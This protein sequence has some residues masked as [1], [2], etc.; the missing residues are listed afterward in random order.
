MATLPLILSRAKLTN[1]ERIF[2][3]AS[4]WISPATTFSLVDRKT[5]TIPSVFTRASTATYFDRNGIL[6][7]AA[8]NEP[9]IEWDPATGACL[10]WRIWDAVTN[11][12]R[13]STMVGA[14]AG[15]PGTLPT[16]WSQFFPISGVTRTVVGTG[17]ENGIDYLDLRLAGTPSAAGSYFLQFDT[18]TSAVASNGQTWTTSVFLKVASG[19]LTGIN[20]VLVSTSNRNSL[21]N[22][23]AAGSTSVT[24]T[25][26]LRRFSSTYTNADA[27]T[28]YEIGLIELQLSGAA[29]EITLRVGLPQLERAGAA[30]PVVKTS[31]VAASSTADVAS[32]TGAAFAGIWNADESTIVCKFFSDNTAGSGR[33]S[34]LFDIGA[35]GAF[36]TTGYGVF[37]NSAWFI[38]PAV[39]PMN[40]SSAVA[41]S[42]GTKAI[43]TMAA[44]FKA[45]DS[46]I[47]VN[48][49][50]GTLDS[51]CAVPA[52]PTTLYIGRSGWAGS[53]NYANGYIQEFA[54]LKSGRPDPNITAVSAS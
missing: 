37:E 6:Q 30:G 33:T 1:R 19:S 12:I 7:T 44:R 40:L 41:V 46:R 10:G 8:V 24:V 45:N 48:G 36:G 51:S 15:T 31:G 26:N 13:N 47:A 49:T 39:A 43:G 17:T 14:V 34:L 4:Y 29:I 54:T 2:S 22:V 16:N 18:N 23:I 53:A 3:E 11:S 5:G 25:S 32:I 28:A 20:T 35:G 27:N 50:L 9:V 21:G 38:N 42:A 52:S